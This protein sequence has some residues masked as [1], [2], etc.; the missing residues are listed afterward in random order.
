MQRRLAS[1]VRSSKISAPQL[2]DQ[3]ANP[4]PN[5][6]DFRP[7]NERASVRRRPSKTATRPRT[8]ALISH[9]LLVRQRTGLANFSLRL[10]RVKE[11]RIPLPLPSGI[12]PLPVSSGDNTAEMVRPAILLRPSI[13]EVGRSRPYRCEVR[14]KIGRND[15]CPCGSG[16]KFKRCCGALAQG[17][18]PK[19][20][21]R[22]LN[23]IAAVEREREDEQGRGRPIISK[24]SRGIRFIRVGN[25]DYQNSEQKWKT[26]HDF[27]FSYIRTVLGGRWAE[28]ELKKPKPERHELF[29][30]FEAAVGD[31]RRAVDAHGK[32]PSRIAHEDTLA[33]LD[34]A[35]NLYLIAH[36]VGDQ[37]SLIR[38][39]KAPTAF[40]PTCYE[41][42][43]AGAF[44]RAGFRLQYEDETDPTSKHCE[45]IAAHPRTRKRFSVE[46][47]MRRPD[48]TSADV[49]N[50]LYAALSKSFEHTRIIFIE[51]NLPG[52]LDDKSRPVR[53]TEI[54][55]S[56]RSREDKLKVD[57]RPAPPAYIVVTNNPR[58]YSGETTASK[59]IIA[60][61]FKIPD[62]RFEGAFLSLDEALSSRERHVEVTG[63]MESFA[64]HFSVPA[65]FD[66]TDPDL[67][68]TGR[69]LKLGNVYQVAEQDGSAVFAE[70][71]NACVSEREKKAHLFFKMEDGRV[72]LASSPMTDEELAGELKTPLELYDW[73]YTIYKDTPKSRLLHLLS[74]SAEFDSI[75]SLSRIELVKIVCERYVRGVHAI[76]EEPAKKNIA[77]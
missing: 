61:G 73:F 21:Q 63:L 12:R 59:W 2:S 8:L 45:F 68:I 57:K 39:L 24:V 15:P 70:L 19:A 9:A 29:N 14:T 10:I 32:I 6:Q 4:A 52:D 62:F 17:K 74:K 60:E 28:D 54:L 11:K 64:Q 41:I 37:P 25:R 51:V 43:V 1:I 72:R 69:R 55:Q 33:F 31:S 46:A 50:Q 71:Q 35:Y 65:T 26:F 56:L 16:E 30:W 22:Q 42:G 48:K 67:S 23:E 49:G 47:K 3:E 75:K 66:G 20:I 34:L 76:S 77:A 58:Y 7:P 18:I 44:I 13:F 40:L 36:N 38:R 53:L 27:L 5:L